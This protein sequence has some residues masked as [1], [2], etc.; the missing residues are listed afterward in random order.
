VDTS[1]R[2]VEAERAACGLP[3]GSATFRNRAGCGAG[4]FDRP[5]GI[6]INADDILYVA[7]FNNFR[8]QRFNT[9]GM[10]GGEAVSECDGTCFVLGDFGK[11]IDVSVNR[12]HFYVLD[13]EFDLLHV[14]ETTPITNV[15]DAN[16]NLTQNAFVTY[17]SDNNF[18]GLDTFEFTVGD[19]LANSAPAT[20]T[21]N[22]S[23]NHRP[24]EAIAASVETP[25]DTGVDIV[26]T[27]TDPD[28]DTLRFAVVDAPV[29]GTLEGEAPNLRYVP[30]ENFQGRDAFA[31]VVDDGLTSSPAAT[32][33]PAFVTIDVLP[34]PDDPTLEVEFA[35]RTGVAYDTDFAAYSFDPDVGDIASVTI[36]WGDGD[37]Q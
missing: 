10:L 3:P 7:D 14:F 13:R 11:P 35:T 37:V 32:S 27:G 19:G 33:E 26:L 12:K 22:V 23:R 25:E 36:E 24:P 1:L 5:R 2:D 18:R 4:Q 30:N 6:A 17:R 20:V 34:A 29:N 15:Q 31:F 21:V 16:L 28:A 8:I 9:D